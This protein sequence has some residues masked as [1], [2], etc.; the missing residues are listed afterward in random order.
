MHVQ[1]LPASSGRCQ[2]R[3]QR[4]RA[5]GRIPA[6]QLQARGVAQ[7]RRPVQPHGH[8]LQRRQRDV[9]VRVE[10]WQDA[11]GVRRTTVKKKP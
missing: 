5:R 7:R 2:C 8:G 6:G 11:P 10:G 3:L 1:A 9:I 4:Q